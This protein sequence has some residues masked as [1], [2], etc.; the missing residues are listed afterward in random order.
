MLG[1]FYRKIIYIL[2]L[3]SVFSSMTFADSS[4]IKKI[5]FRKKGYSAEVID[6]IPIDNN[7]SFVISWCDASPDDNIGFNDH[8]VQTFNNN[9]NKISKPITVTGAG[10]EGPYLPDVTSNISN[11]EFI[12]GYN[13]EDGM[14]I[15]RFKKNGDKIGKEKRIGNYNTSAGSYITLNSSSKTGDFITCFVGQREDYKEEGSYI[16]KFDANNL[17]QYDKTKIE[18]FYPT[19]CNFIGDNGDFIITGESNIQRF[20]KYGSMIG[21]EISIPTKNYEL[22]Y[23]NNYDG[24]HI[25]SLKN[26][27]LVFDTEMINIFSNKANHL[28]TIKKGAMFIISA[29]EGKHF[30]T[31][32]VSSNNELSIQKFNQ[33]GESSSEKIRFQNIKN[34]SSPVEIKNGFVIAMK[35]IKNEL[36]VQKFDINLSPVGNKIKLITHKAD[37][38]TIFYVPKNDNI[39]ILLKK[40]QGLC[41]TEL[42]LTKM[43]MNSSQ[44]P[45]VKLNENIEEDKRT[46]DEDEYSSLLNVNSWKVE[47][48]VHDHI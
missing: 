33:Y 35:N 3:I 15:Q 10:S 23:N 9:G 31:A 41:E 34:I 19:N 24:S 45:N 22:D 25:L 18:N 44:M 37:I 36:F 48:E 5:E 7:G 47:R 46:N 11:E 8:M 43:D 17:I 40:G 12:I 27:F 6:I 21:D 26:N 28:K 14:K 38:E 30:V 20:D 39:M 32:N 2:L 42:F 29:Q 1:F 13:N 16:Q 4:N